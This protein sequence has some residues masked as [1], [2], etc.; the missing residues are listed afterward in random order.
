MIDQK[1]GAMPP[2]RTLLCSRNKKKNTKFNQ[3]KTA[4][5]TIK[6]IETETP[7]IKTHD[8]SNKMLQHISKVLDSHSTV[9]AAEVHNTIDSAAYIDTNFDRYPQLVQLAVK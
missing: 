7:R 4:F 3:L 9:P 1:R 8:F 5:Q 6:K 2:P